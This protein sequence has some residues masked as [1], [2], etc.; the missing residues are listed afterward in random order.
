MARGRIELPTRGF[1]LL[2]IPAAGTSVAVPAAKR[3]CLTVTV[4]TQ[5]P[6]IVRAVVVVDSVD[7]IENE[8]E[9]SV[10]PEGLK[11]TQGALVLEYCSSNQAKLEAMA[12]GVSH[13]APEPHLVDARRADARDANDSYRARVV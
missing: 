5:Q 9:R 1:S 10:L 6:Q 4:W 8:H 2:L 11:S 12:V 13:Q 3:G 7:V